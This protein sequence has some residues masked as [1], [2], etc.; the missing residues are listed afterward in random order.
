MHYMQ[1][2]CFIYCL[3]L[4]CSLVVINRLHRCLVIQMCLRKQ[5]IINSIGLS[6]NIAHVNVN[7]F[8]VLPTLLNHA[9]LYIEV[10]VTLFTK[11]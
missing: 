3:Q 6:D 4:L 10:T 2:Y 5:K 11:Y 7:P 1:F 9:V 8:R